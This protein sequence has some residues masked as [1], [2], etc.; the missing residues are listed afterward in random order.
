M[1][2]EGTQVLKYMMV[3]EWDSERG[4]PGEVAGGIRCVQLFSPFKDRSHSPLAT[5]I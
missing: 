5:C 4:L 2:Q 1:V 3:Y